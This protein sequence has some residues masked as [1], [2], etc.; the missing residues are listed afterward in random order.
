MTTLFKYEM[1]IHTKGCSKDG[2]SDVCE[3]IDKA[4][5]EGYSGFVIT[6][7][8]YR[9]NT[10]IDRD[11]PWHEFV[12]AYKNDYLTAKEYGDKIDFDVLFGVEEA[13]AK[14]KEVLIYGLSPDVI[15]AEPGFKQMDLKA[16]SDFVRKNGG[17]IACAHPFRVRP[18][19]PDPD[20]EPDHT[21]LD[22][23]E[24]YNSHNNAEEN[25]K[26][27]AFAEKYGLIKTSG[28]DVHG[29]DRFDVVGID[30]KIRI[31]DNKTLLAVLRS[32]DYGL[33]EKR[34]T[35]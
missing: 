34:K 33:L 17:I 6:N 22:A 26:A 29:T 3:M 5:E 18:S 7:H 14:G 8:F 23:V 13:Y 25:G 28:G 35:D 21:C 2:R 4:V 16:M 12:G 24:V 30:S 11:L 32:G 1:H 31:R 15:A 9:G 10:G 27:M 19:I 20:A